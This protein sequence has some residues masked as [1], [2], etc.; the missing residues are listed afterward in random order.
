MNRKLGVVSFFGWEEG[1]VVTIFQKR[2]KLQEA[3]NLH[4]T[5]EQKLSFISPQLRP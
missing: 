4:L 5:E 1:L 2:I 3:L